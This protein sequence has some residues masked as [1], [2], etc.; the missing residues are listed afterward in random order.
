MGYHQFNQSHII[1]FNDDSIWG[2]KSYVRNGGWGI[3]CCSHSGEISIEHHVSK[4]LHSLQ[5]LLLALKGH[6]WVY[7]PWWREFR[8]LM[9]ANELTHVNLI[10]GYALETGFSYVELMLCSCIWKPEVVSKY[11]VFQSKSIKIV[12]FVEISQLLLLT[13]NERFSRASSQNVGK[14]IVLTKWT[15]KKKNLSSF[16]CVVWSGMWLYVIR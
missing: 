1:L 6:S 3:T 15:V 10:S 12:L 8:Q 11:L 14:I 16:H 7:L 5:L 2:D 9:H 13:W 4:D